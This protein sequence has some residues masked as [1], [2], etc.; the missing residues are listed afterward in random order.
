[1]AKTAQQ[2]EAIRD[3][4]R[5][6]AAIPGH[7]RK[8][9]TARWSVHS[10]TT[11]LPYAVI[12]GIRGLVCERPQAKFGRGLRKH[13]AAVEVWLA[14]QWASLHERAATVIKRP[15]VKHHYGCK[16]ARIARDGHRW[17]KR[18][19]PKVP[20]PQVQQKVFRHSQTKGPSRAHRGYGRR[21]ELGLHGNVHVRCSPRAC[22]EGSPLSSVYDMPTGG[23][24]WSPH[25][26][27]R[28]KA[29]SVDRFQAA[30]RRD[31]LQGV[32]QGSVS[33]HGHGSAR[34]VLTGMVSPKKFGAKPLRMF[35]R[36]ALW[37]G[38]APW[39]FVTDGLSAFVGPAKKAF[40]RNTGRRFVHA[41][42][43]HP[44]THATFRRAP[45]GT[46]SRCSAGAAASRY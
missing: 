6:I 21:P 16:N 27:A 37:A 24:V 17:T 34:F 4:G 31:M 43:I 28:Q 14:G 33:F 2:R 44:P 38:V 32:G 15:S 22:Q 20:V 41:A 19:G 30:L 9:G 23:K 26:G 46:S 35:K 1:M 5:T 36:T 42:E 3:A 25:G 39:I 12:L 45:T 40:W 29:Q 11:L 18:R 8:A 10:Q 7:I 13:A